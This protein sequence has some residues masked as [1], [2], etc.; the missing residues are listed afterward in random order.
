MERGLSLSY[1]NTLCH[2]FDADRYDLA[3]RSEISFFF[4]GIWHTRNL[5]GWREREDTVE[6]VLKLASNLSHDVILVLTLSLEG[7]CCCS[8][9]CDPIRLPRPWDSGQSV[10][11]ETAE[12]ITQ[13]LSESLS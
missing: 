11:E 8:T 6:K 9:L 12:G 1:L 5:H 13:R 4:R 10:T 3:N 7:C 2:S